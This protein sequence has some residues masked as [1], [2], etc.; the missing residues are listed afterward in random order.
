MHLICT[1]FRY[2]RIYLYF[3]RLPNIRTKGSVGGYTREIIDKS[4]VLYYV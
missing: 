3:Y 4:R 1:Y 2:K